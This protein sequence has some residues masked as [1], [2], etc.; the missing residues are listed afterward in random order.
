VAREAGEADGRIRGGTRSAGEDGEDRDKTAAAQVADHGA[1][2]TSR[3]T[4]GIRG[5]EHALRHR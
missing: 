4:V 3:L 5:R 2:A 1:D